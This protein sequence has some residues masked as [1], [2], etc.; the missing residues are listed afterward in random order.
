M[1]TMIAEASFA[2]QFFTGYLFFST[3]A[4]ILLD[5]DNV[6]SQILYIDFKIPTS[7]LR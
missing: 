1:M 7:I 2:F 6:K 3:L 4:Y 5:L